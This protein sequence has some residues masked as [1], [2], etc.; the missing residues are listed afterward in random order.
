MTVMGS[1]CLHFDCNLSAAYW[2]LNLMLSGM[3]LETTIT[4]GLCFAHSSKGCPSIFTGPK[5][6][7]QDISLRQEVQSPRSL[8]STTSLLNLGSMLLHRNDILTWKVLSHGTTASLNN[9]E[10][11]PQSGRCDSSN[12]RNGIVELQLDCI[13]KHW[14][15]WSAGSSSTWLHESG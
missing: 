13:L 2:L 3:R 8:Q 9:L 14:S 1:K 6:A 4:S 11:A 5:T 10:L 12:T 15:D 7:M